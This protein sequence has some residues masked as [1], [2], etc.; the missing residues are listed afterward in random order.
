MSLRYALMCARVCDTYVWNKRAS[1]CLRFGFFQS[2]FSRIY[3]VLWGGEACGGSLV[4]ELRDAVMSCWIYLDRSLRG[5]SVI[6]LAI[7]CHFS[8]VSCSISNKT[9]VLPSLVHFKMQ[10]N[11]LL[12][13]ERLIALQTDFTMTK[14]LNLNT[15]L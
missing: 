5:G 7:L 10:L 13:P 15:M 3:F 4:S 14:T 6:A 8:S 2:I 9:R 1:A 12:S 11:V